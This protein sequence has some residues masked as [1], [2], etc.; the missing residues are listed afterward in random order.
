MDILDRTNIRI[1][2]A[3]QK[4]GRLTN[5]ELGEKIG[6]SPSQC[7]RRRSALEESGIIEGYTARVNRD[8]LNMGLTCLVSVRLATHNPDNARRLVTLFE[9]LPYVLEAHSMTGSTDYIVKIVSRDL[10]S[11]ATL[12]N[13]ELLPHDAVQNVET[14]VVLETLKETSAIP[15]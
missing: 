15:I 9:R 4:D 6:L 10:K 8:K 12:I 14:S 2:E 3:L 13:E 5:Q 7:S 11:L 1:L